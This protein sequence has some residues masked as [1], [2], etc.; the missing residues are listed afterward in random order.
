MKKRVAIFL[1]GGIGGGIASQGFPAIAKITDG[2]AQSFDVD[3][4]SLVPP[5]AGFRP[6]TYGMFSSATWLRGSRLRKL[7]W[8]SLASRF[9]SAHRRRPYDL[10]MSFWGYPVGT[11]MLALAALVRR[12]SVVTIL[13]AEAAS[14]PSIGYGHLRQPVT[15]RLVVATCARA[16]AVVV[17]SQHQKEVLRRAGLRREDLEV[18]PFGMDRALFTFERRS[19]SPP[20]KLLHVANLTAVKDQATLLRG[21]ALL[22]QQLKAKMRIVGPDH[23]DG[24]LQK[25]AAELGIEDDV[26]F[27]GPLPY[28]AIPAQYRWADMFVLTSLSES[29]NNALMEAAMSGVLQVTTPVGHI[30]DL[31]DEIAVVAR[32]GDPVDLAAKI[33]AAL[34]DQAGWER[35]V[36]RARAWA[37]SHDLRWTIDRLSDVINRTAR[38]T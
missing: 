23:L 37:E 31:G 10:L 29:Q 16:S 24:K 21:F 22:R 14:V 19:L 2:L 15:R 4:F 7:R 38:W 28:A 11:F 25:L 27:V 20:L 32:T 12:P 17:V 35:R 5:D 8:A 6:T 18:I 33:A 3:V 9:L 30:N 26:E 34:G 1:I 36:V 13:G